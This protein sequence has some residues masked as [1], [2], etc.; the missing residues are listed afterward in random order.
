MT[1][2]QLVWFKHD[3][4]LHDHAPLHEAVQCGP[5]ICMYV[6]EPSLIV[7]P[8]FAVAHQVFTNQSLK[9]LR[10]GLRALGGELTLRVSEVLNVVEEPLAEV[11]FEYIWAHEETG[12]FASYERDQRAWA[13]ASG[14]PFTELP[15]NGLIRRSTSRDGWAKKWQNA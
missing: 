14:I 5:V 1:A 8:E 15:N 2:P 9:E 4:G 12:T 11:H 3:L 10:Q 6:Y 13:K 7:H